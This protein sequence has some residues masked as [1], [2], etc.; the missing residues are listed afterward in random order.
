MLVVNV[1][2]VIGP[3]IATFV[4]SLTNWP[5]YG[6]LHFIG[7]ANYSS[8]VSSSD[9]QQ[10]VIHNLEWTAAFLTIPV[11]LGLLGAFAVSQVPRGQKFFRTIFFLPYIVQPVV[12]ASLWTEIYAGHFGIGALSNLSPLGNPSLALWSVALA[13]IWCWWGFLAV[14]FLSAM[15]AVPRELYEAASLDGAGPIRQAWSITLPGIRSTLNFMLMMSVIWSMLVFTY[16]YVMTGGGPAGA[17][18]VVATLLYQDA[19]QSQEVGLAAAMGVMLVLASSLVGVG[20][21]FL[22][23]RGSYETV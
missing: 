17:S 13:N 6:P 12:V 15:Q 23:R 7:L 4:Y 10:A 21:V 5:G 16:I 8:I 11:F 9:F 1:L 14:V 18:Q 20:Y 22:S 3:C 2:V 19:F